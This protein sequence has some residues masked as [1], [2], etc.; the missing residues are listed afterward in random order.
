MKQK[1]KDLPVWIITMLTI[2]PVLFVVLASF[3]SPESIRETFSGIVNGEG[4]ENYVQFRHI[5]FGLEQYLEAFAATPQYWYN[6]WNSVVL[7]LPVLLGTVAIA[8][9]AGYGFAKF[10]FQGKQYAFKLFLILMLL[11]YQVR[12]IPDFYISSNMGFIGKR[13]AIILPGIFSPFGCYLMYQSIRHISDTTLEMAKVEGAGHFRILWKIVLPQALPGLVS[14]G[15]LTLID[16]WN[17]IE[18]PLILLRNEQLYPLSVELQRI[19]TED[20]GI[21]FACAS[22][23]LIPV[24]LAFLAGKELLTEGI[25]NTYIQ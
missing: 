16:I 1:W 17:M 6:F 12:L 24:L 20:L 10:R 18:Q 25:A 13:I 23:Y 11:P 14:L 22:I 8:T 4:R 5:S 21:A 9:L 19:G 3:L 15:I 7:V 2:M